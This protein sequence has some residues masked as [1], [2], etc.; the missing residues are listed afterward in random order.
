MISRIKKN[1]FFLLIFLG[2][3]FVFA[4]RYSYLPMPIVS[5]PDSQVWFSTQDSELEQTWQ[6]TVKRISGI[7]IPYCAENSFTADVRLKI[8]NDDY[9]KVL[10]ETKAE[11]VIFTEGENGE[12]PFEFA[13]TSIRQ[14]ERIRIQLALLDAS[15]EGTLQIAAGSNYGGCTISGEEYGQAAA[16]KIT[17]AKY[18]RLFWLTAIL[19]PL[20]AF[21]LFVMILAG[22]KWEET[23]ALAIF[24]EGIILYIF[25]WTEHL[26]WGI[27]AVYL[28]SLAVMLAAVYFYNKKSLKLRELLSPGLW[29]YFILF[30]VI[31]LTT[32]GDWLGNRDELRHWGIAVRDM[33]Y[34][35]SFAKHANSTVILVRYLPFAALIEY[36]FEYMNGMFSEEILFM[37]YQT[38]LLSVTVIMCKPL[39]RKGWK[40]LLLPVMAA[41]ICIPVLF[42]N[43]I[44]SSIMVDSLM[45]VII[46]YALVCYFSEK[47]SWF[48]G[49][50]ITCSLM[51]LPLIKDI[52]L[53][54]S[55]IA[56][57]I[58]FGDIVLAQFRKKKMN[59]KE[60]LFPIICVLL[61]MAVYFSWQCYLNIP[62]KSESRINNQSIEETDE[63]I[64][65]QHQTMQES[66][67][68]ETE[69]IE[70]AVAVESAVSASGITI[71]G[72]KNIFTGN[73]EWYQ[74]QTTRNFIIELLDGDTYSLGFFKISF[75]DL[76]FL[77][78][79]LIGSLGYF[80]YWQN[81]KCRI[82]TFAGMILVAGACFCAFL[83]LTYW[84]TF[85]MYEAMDL[86]SVDRYLAPFPCGIIMVIFFMIIDGSQSSQWKTSKSDYLLY[87]L[88]VLLIIGTPVGGLVIESKDIEG[89]TTEE[90]IYGYSEIAEVL[91]SVA[92]KGERAY[93][94]CSNSDGYAEY[95]FRN[96]VCPIVSEHKNWNIV[97]TKELYDQQYELYDE[98]QVTVNNVAKILPFETWKEEVRKCK[99][100]VVFHADELFYQSYGELF[101]ETA[102][103]DGSIY[104]V[105]DKQ[106]DVSLRLMGVVGI[107]A[108]H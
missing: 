16:F 46:G 58:I 26:I 104:Q 95:I 31:L 82:Y 2:L 15:A 65:Q 24:A 103:T 17:F 72:L 76:L 101:A 61:A 11:D 78:V 4:K 75:V 84:F 32:N 54:L 39:Q 1:W 51:I 99:Y 38:M 64:T 102:I 81:D 83:Q 40:K 77:V 52:G 49:I 92:D 8:F 91:R 96:T 43:N 35:D 10:V 50:R 6:P 37:A 22:R 44:S 71:E 87:V 88:T 29:I 59:A 86:T 36:L 100:V 13:R 41:M 27:G 18:S 23:V 14:G 30:V 9:S 90:N 107:K 5:N 19:F 34:Y 12:I 60:I 67:T 79:M 89:N 53:A 28:L 94:V 45:A 106:G 93:F 56:A 21:S 3:I 33:F 98:G 7:Q 97:S 25:G 68:Q 66:E 55:G 69:E 85:S 57:L 80:G 62:V 108:Y 73:G 20:L 63:A 70:E 42:F 74:Y 48:N 47:M 105:L